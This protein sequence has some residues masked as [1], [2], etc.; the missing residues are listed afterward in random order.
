MVDV[1]TGATIADAARK[2]FESR[3]RSLCSTE[4]RYEDSSRRYRMRAFARVKRPDGC[5]PELI[6]TDYSEPFTI[7]AWYES[8]GLPPMKI[9]LPLI[10]KNF[11]KKMKPNVAFSM[12]EDL[13]NLMQRNTTNSMPGLGPSGPTVDLGLMWLCSFNIP[14]ITVCAFIVLNIFLSLFNIFF[15]WLLFIK[16]CLPIPVPTPKKSS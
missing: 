5:P 11:M 15:S 12:P 9:Q 1:A 10:D 14:I 2:S 4:T 13:F 16:V 8:S 6:W 7:A 3:L